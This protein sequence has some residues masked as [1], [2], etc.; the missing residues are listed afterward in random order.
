MWSGYPHRL[1]DPEHPDW[2][3]DPASPTGFPIMSLSDWRKLFTQQPGRL[4]NEY[5]DH[6]PDPVAWLGRG[7]NRGRP[8]RTGSTSSARTS[9][10]ETPPDP[11]GY[12][13]YA[14]DFS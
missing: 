5:G 6:I 14:R 3:N 4:F 13:F 7:R 2:G 9:G 11:D 12:R 8:A 1:I 10:P